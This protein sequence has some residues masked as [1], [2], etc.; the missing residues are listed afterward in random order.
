MA[1]NSFRVN[2]V[3]GHLYDK[4]RI[5]IQG[6]F[7]NGEPEKN[8]IKI[9]LDDEQIEYSI[10]RKDDYSIQQKYAELNCNVEV[11]YNIFVHFHDI[12]LSK[13][14]RF[15]ILNVEGIN[16][17]EVLNISTKKLI[18][19]IDT[20]NYNIDVV[21]KAGKDIVIEG[22]A[23]YQHDFNV[24][25]FDECNNLV[26]G[27]LS[28]C[29]RS[30]LYSAYP[31]L[32]NQNGM[33][34]FCYKF[35]MKKLGRVKLVIN[36]DDNSHEINLNLKEDVITTQG[37][38]RKTCNYVKKNGIKKSVRRL[39]TRIKSS[40]VPVSNQ[41]D[42][43]TWIRKYELS[44]LNLDGQRTYRF[45]KEIKFSIVTPLYNTPKKY[46][47]PMIVSVMNQTYS[48]WELCFADGSTD[49]TVKKVVDLY[50]SKDS[51]IKY[52]KL[53]Q[54]NGISENTNAALE[55]A[56]GD[57]IVLADHDDILAP[58]ALFEFAKIIEDNEDADVIYSDED[59][60]SMDG[61]RRFEPHF[62]PDFNIDL[63]C[64][65]NY[66]C[67][68]FTARKSL[69]D[70]VGHFN[71]DYDGAQDYDLI[72]RCVENAEAVYHVPKILYHW[73]S[74][75]NSTASNPESKMYAFE[76]GKRAIAAHF[77][78]VGMKAEVEHGVAY[79]IYHVKLELERPMKV[80]I[81]IPNKDHIEDLRKCIE[82]IINKTNYKHYE[83]IVIENNSTESETFEFYK[84][85]EAEYK[86]VKV[87]YWDKEFNYSLINNFGVQYA[88]GEYLLFLNND[89]EV[90]N[91]TWLEEML[92]YC[93]REDVGIVG[94]RLL[95]PDDTVQ[96]AGVI[97]GF[98]G[99]AGH[100][101]IGQRKDELG[102]FGRSMCIQDYS[103]VTAACMMT[104]KSV[105]EDVGGFS[106]ELKVAFNDIDYCMK[107]RAT[108]KLVVYNPYVELYHYESKSRGLED[109]PEKIQR[110]NGEM[111]IFRKRWDRELKAGDPYYNPNLSLNRSDFAFKS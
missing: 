89:T 9:F 39:I 82:S 51:R 45:E 85:L 8:E 24:Q 110:F 84:K 81:L 5:V 42:Y 69:I 80:S 104:K 33:Y 101:F 17:E 53:E 57:Y 43:Y 13:Y 12:E 28:H 2:Y 65:V 60:V 91:P 29:N 25:I 67:H 97:I 63:L 68:L 83:I 105:F 88:T 90:I 92:G 15:V 61:K 94:A 99:I 22:W 7:L 47:V 37:L 103:A 66:I 76:A 77:D 49:E 27:A 1:Q 46:L 14:S 40:K 109:T 4:N 38:V 30:D 64:S 75:I 21:N 36:I 58:N 87:V 106:E 10:E 111:D 78:R 16:E 72:L 56:I 26:D 18:K 34:G 6:C 11:E 70:R 79:G 23:I 3:R 48:N 59:K 32:S 74:H 93:Q 102:Y 50:K 71:K 31:E 35:S 19:L 20:S 54:N 98:G 96:H 62:K 107:V 86:N 55:M 52:V 108:N 95:Y 73:R 41:P 44:K 100:A